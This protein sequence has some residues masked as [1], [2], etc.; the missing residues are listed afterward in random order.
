[1][2]MTM[3]LMAR[4]DWL[5]ESSK[6]G[7]FKRDTPRTDETSIVSDQEVKSKVVVCFQC[8]QEGH[9]AWGCVQPRRSS[10]QEN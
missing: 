9:F 7:Y 1:M 5:E 6:R 8:G 10:N 2:E 3:Q 4:M